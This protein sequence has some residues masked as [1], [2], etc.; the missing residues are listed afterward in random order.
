MNNEVWKDI[1]GYDG[2][3]QVSNFGRVRSFKQEKVRFLKPGLGYDGRQCVALHKKNKRK[4]ILIHT[5]VLE[6]FVCKRPKGKVCRHLNG[7]PSDNRVENLT[8]GTQLENY[9]DAIRH[10]TRESNLS[11]SLVREIRS[12]SHELPIKEIAKKYGI[13]ASYTYAVVN[14]KT[15]KHV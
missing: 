10:G 6:A 1:D 15:W 8:W 11:E 9:Q 14:R 3:Y 2:K 12:I 7:D 5:L 13:S 4:G